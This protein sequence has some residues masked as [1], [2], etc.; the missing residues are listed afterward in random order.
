MFLPGQVEYYVCITDLNKLSIQKLPKKEMSTII[1]ELSDN[2]M[3][4]LGRHFVLNVTRFQLICYRI[5]EVFI[6]KETRLKISI[7]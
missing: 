4:V 3:S 5:F 7:H 1:T 6:A 2:F